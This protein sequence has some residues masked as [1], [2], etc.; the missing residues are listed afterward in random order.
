MHKVKTQRS[1]K[2]FVKNMLIFKFFYRVIIKNYSKKNYLTNFR[3]FPEIFRGKFP[4]ISELTTLEPLVS[5]SFH[6][7]LASYFLICLRKVL[8]I[9]C[10]K[11]TRVSR[12]AVYYC[13]WLCVLPCQGH[14]EFPFWK[15]KIPPAKE[16]IPE[17]SRS[18]KCLILHALT[19]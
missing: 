11:F 13:Y 19:Q 18:V 2:L 14:R 5:H 17:N 4:E 1:G 15:R 16:K 6:I 8:P 7:G 10:C 9:T 3:K 12:C